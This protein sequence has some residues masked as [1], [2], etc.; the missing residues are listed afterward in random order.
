MILAAT[1]GYANSYQSD[2]DFLK[3]GPEYLRT[4]Q[5]EGFDG[6]EKRLGNFLDVASLG[7][8]GDDITIGLISRLEP[9]KMPALNAIGLD[10]SGNRATA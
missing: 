8:R 3:I 1:D 2:D 4:V 5:A 7:L 6:I 9:Q 10:D